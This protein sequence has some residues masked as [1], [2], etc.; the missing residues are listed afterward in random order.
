MPWCH[1]RVRPGSPQSSE[2]QTQGR[3]PA[4]GPA[5]AG[6]FRAG[7]EFPESSRGQSGTPRTPGP[8]LTYAGRYIDEVEQRGRKREE[9]ERGEQR[10]AR[11]PQQPPADA[12]AAAG[13]PLEGRAGPAPAV[14]RPSPPG[15]PPPPGPRPPP[16]RPRR[17]PL[18]AAS[19]LL[20]AGR[21]GPGHMK[22]AGAGAAPSERSGRDGAGR[23]GPRGGAGAGPAP[24][25]TDVKDPRARVL[26]SRLPRQPS[27]N[28]AK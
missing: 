25:G 12:H 17:P 7:R 8:L 28:V 21:R 20:A 27:G 15:P 26:A 18:A 19:P 9:E 23:G 16:P 3:L 2:G 1:P 11:Q 4:G 10:A 22:R 5:R 14:P 24:P 6:P 13:R